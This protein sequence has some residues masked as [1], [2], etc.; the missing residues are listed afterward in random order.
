MSKFCVIVAVSD[1]GV[2]GRDGKLPW[3]FPEDLQHFK[4]LTMG[5]PCVMGRNTFL[6][7]GRP[8]PGRKNI[9]VTSTPTGHQHPDLIE[10]KTLTEA[11]AIA[12]GFGSD[13]VF[14]IGGARIFREALNWC[15]ELY[16]TRVQ[17]CFEGDVELEVKPDLYKWRLLSTDV[18][19][20]K[21]EKNPG[22]IGTFQRWIRR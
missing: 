1:N 3:H 17:G 14:F 16:V 11:M 8:L 6:D 5:K 19:Q 13:R 20:S 4:K 9:V 12:V 21:S 7:I 22:L 2:I 10:V 18:V 15:S